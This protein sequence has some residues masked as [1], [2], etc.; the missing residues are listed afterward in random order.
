MI[1]EDGLRGMTSNPS[2]FEKAIA[3]SDCF[4]DMLEVTA[5]RAAI[6]MRPAATR[7]SRFATF[8]MRP[9]F[10]RPVY[11]SSNAAMAMS[12]W[13]FRLISRTT[14]R[15]TI[16]EARRLWKSV[17]R[18]NVMIK[19]PGTAEGIPA[20]RNRSAKASTSTSPYC[21]A[22]EVYEEVAEAYIAGVENFAA[23]G[24]DVSKVAS[25]ASFFISRIDSA[26]RFASRRK[27]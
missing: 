4:S 27:D 23:S 17:Q 25:V 15:D 8:R 1:E 26:G 5:D 18:E 19:V 22:Q 13:K 7:C 20:F 6:W 3:D 12:A 2:I 16:E 10:L 24:G 21:S 14:L 11:E 9:T